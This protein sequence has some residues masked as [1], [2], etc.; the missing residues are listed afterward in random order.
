MY[1]GVVAMIPCAAHMCECRLVLR[2]MH[3]AHFWY[4][5]IAL[6]RPPIIIVGYRSTERN[7][8]V[9]MTKAVNPLNAIRVSG[10]KGKENIMTEEHKTSSSFKR[11]YS[12]NCCLRQDHHRQEQAPCQLRQ[13]GSLFEAFL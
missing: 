7:A 4:R 12:G 5:Q 1:N 10:N 11:Q 2:H 13:Q 8:V 6:R 3:A 9:I